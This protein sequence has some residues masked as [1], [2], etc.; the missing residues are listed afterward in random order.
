MPTNVS[1]ETGNYRV[2]RQVSGFTEVTEWTDSMDDLVAEYEEL[3]RAAG[4][5][6][7]IETRDGERFRIQKVKL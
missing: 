1:S 4:G 5:P 7:Y 3:Q 2:T 6:P